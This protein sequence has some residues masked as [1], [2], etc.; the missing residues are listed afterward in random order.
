MHLRPYGLRLPC[1]AFAV[2]EDGGAGVVPY[3]LLVGNRRDPKRRQR[4]QF[5]LV[6]VSHRSL[7]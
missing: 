3:R 1:A 7:L 6:S 4:R 5:D 2:S